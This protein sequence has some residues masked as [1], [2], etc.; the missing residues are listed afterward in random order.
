M[1]ILEIFENESISLDDEDVKS[2]FQIKSQSP[3]LPF[4]ILDNKLVAE[5][6][7]IGEIQLKNKLIRIKPRHKV[8][9]LNHYFEML[10]YIDKLNYN[11]IKS[12]SYSNET[13]FGVNG[14]IENFIKICFDL[15]SY[16]LTGLF[17]TKKIKSFKPK[18]KIIFS[19][20][21]KKLIPIEGVPSLIEDYKI[22]NCG[23]QIIKTAVLKIQEYIRLS[24][25]N[26]FAILKL[27]S[28]FENV[29]SYNKDYINLKSEVLNFCSSNPYYPIALEYS[30]KIILDF[31]L[32]YSSEGGIQ[33]NAFLENSNDT[34]EKYIREILERELENKICK[35]NIPKKFAEINW[36]KESGQKAF[37]PDIIVDFIDG[38]A[39][40]VFDI[41]NKYF[42]PVETNPSELA[43]V[44]D[45]YQLLFY[46]NQL[47]TDICG[48]I[49]PSGSFYE[50]I[51]LNIM[52]VDIKFFLLS[53]NMNA[54][55]EQRKKYFLDSVKYCLKYT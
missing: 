35:W 41:K 7:T 2:L 34:F 18:G 5:D 48:L 47:K 16:G 40:A 29:N 49:Y 4:S 11:S 8:L 51:P 14:L 22:D 52:G 12:V 55:F 46:S 30:L 42:S 43:S 53:I 10:L 54:N 50:P 13:S 44:A 37:S 39:K 19:E 32:G 33:W 28:H 25:D 36:N 20:F 26:H 15:L 23:N 17:T 27:L 38:K 3:N 6:Y 9:S 21:N 24:K 1:K 31:K 45:I